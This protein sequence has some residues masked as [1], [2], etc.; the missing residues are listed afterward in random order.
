MTH[1]RAQ[2]GPRYYFFLGLLVFT[3]DLTWPLDPSFVLLFSASAALRISA[4]IRVSALSVSAARRAL[5]VALRWL[6]RRLISLAL[7]LLSIGSSIDGPGYTD[8]LSATGTV[9]G[10]DVP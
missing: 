9:A 1:G 4:A 10:T 8:S 5:C 6:A 2:I 7:V 3:V